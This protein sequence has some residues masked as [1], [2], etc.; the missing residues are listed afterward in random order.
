MDLGK[1]GGLLAAGLLALGCTH[2][3]QPASTVGTDLAS[4][5][6]DNGFDMG[7]S[8]YQRCLMGHSQNRNADT[9][10]IEGFKSTV[11]SR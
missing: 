3:D 2:D 6:R 5:C 11:E 1:L 7:T 9:A 8:D 4:A 10:T